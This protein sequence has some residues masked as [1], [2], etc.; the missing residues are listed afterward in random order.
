ML[1]GHAYPTFLNTVCTPLCFWICRDETLLMFFLV[2]TDCV[3]HLYVSVTSIPSCRDGNMVWS[4]YNVNVAHVSH[5]SRYHL[6]PT[7]L[8]DLQGRDTSHVFFWSSQIVYFISMCL[9]HLSQA[10]ETV[11]WSGQITMLMWHT[12]PTFLD[13]ICTPLCFW[14]CRDE[15]LLMFFGPYRLRISSLWP[16]VPSLPGCRDGNTVWSEHHNGHQKP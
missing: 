11:I 4:D 13:T 6:H 8:L 15:T 14:I 16:S 10:A 9:S 12:Y 2:Q 3:F 7:L 1:M 5:I